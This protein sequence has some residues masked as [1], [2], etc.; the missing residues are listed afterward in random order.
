MKKRGKLR[1][2]Y[3]VFESVTDRGP[4]LLWILS[5]NH[6][7]AK[8]ATTGTSWYGGDSD[9]KVLPVYSSLEQMPPE[10]RRRVEGAIAEYRK[11]ESQRRIDG[12]LQKA[13]DRE[14]KILK[15][16]KKTA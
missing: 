7:L 2:V 1:Q 4:S 9:L 15:K 16:A 13:K 5:S 3:A 14:A 8:M 6:Q 11:R 10:I 12:A